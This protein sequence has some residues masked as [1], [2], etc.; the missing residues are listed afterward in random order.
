MARGHR[1]WSPPGPALPGGRARVLVIGAGVAGLAAAWR[2]RQGGWTDPIPML[3]LGDAVGGTAASAG[4]ERPCPLGAHYVT[5]PNPE[6]LVMRR[7]LADLGVI[8][9]WSGDRPRYREDML[10]AAPEERLFDRGFWTEGLWPEST[11]A[12]DRAQ[13]AAFAAEVARLRGLRGAD[14][15]PAFSIPVAASSLD[16]ELLALC[17]L[18]F[19]DW[20][21]ARG[22]DAPA[23]RWWVEYGTRDD[24]GTTLAE[25]SAWAGLHY[26]CARR[27]DPAD[28]PGT[29][30]LT[31]PAGNGWLVDRLLARAGPELRLGCVARRV[32]ARADGVEVVY[33]AGGETR[34][35]RADQVILA[36]P[37]PVAARLCGCPVPSPRATPWE[38]VNVYV[39]R[40]PRPRLGLPVAWDNVVRGADSLGYV[41]AGHQGGRPGAPTV[42]SWYRPWLGDPAE[43]RRAMAAETGEQSWARAEAELRRLHPELEIDAVAVQLWG[44]GTVRP[45]V[46]WVPPLD[47]RVELDPR[48]HLAH[49][50]RSGMSL[51]EEAAWHGVRAAEAVLGSAER[52]AG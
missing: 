43:A 3:E 24:Y 19:A 6:N 9:G 33:D 29:D 14:G 36:V 42:L 1:V 44:H 10:C 5:L 31:W 34:A 50:D 35:L 23:F 48:L 27:P 13:H 41:H 32:E 26:H 47:G 25:T 52:W 45:E 30:V 11:S 12:A 16:P 49:T 39:R 8:E 22:W 4:G 2:L 40:A 15:R 28:E 38:V 21:D 18:S 20:L 7:I 46:G 51:F 37:G 17:R